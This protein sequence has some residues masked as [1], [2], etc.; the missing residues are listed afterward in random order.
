MLGKRKLAPRVSPAKTIEGSLSGVI[1]GILICSPI[2]IALFD[3]SLEEGILL[4]L[5]LSLI[6]IFGDLAES[7]IKRLSG[8]K[9]SGS[10]LPGHG[11]VLDRVDSH[12][13][14]TPIL[15]LIIIML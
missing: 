10:I 4:T 9:D 7:L 15:I 6:A 14:A 8:V 2:A 5:G 11:G 3:M 13:L 1:L 12:L